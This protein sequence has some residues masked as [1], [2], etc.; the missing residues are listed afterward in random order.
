MTGQSSKLMSGKK[1]IGS[2]AVRSDLGSEA[3]KKIIASD[4]APYDNWY[5]V[6]AS[7]A[8]EHLFKKLGGNPIP[9]FLASKF[10]EKDVELID[11]DP[12]HYKRAIGINKEIF[13]KM[14]F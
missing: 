2:A 9:S 7:G 6:E 5:W 14:I 12:V 10:L 3:A 4:I 1:R 11:G 8:I 13:T